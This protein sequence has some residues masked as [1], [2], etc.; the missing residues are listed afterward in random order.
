MTDKALL[1]EHFDRVSDDPLLRRAL[2]EPWLT[3]DREMLYA[4][5]YVIVHTSGSSGSMGIFVFDKEAWAGI[6]GVIM[7]RAAAAL[8]GNPLRRG[9]IALCAATH[10]RFGAVTGMKTLP[11]AIFNVQLCSVLDPLSKTIDTLNRF[12]PDYIL[13]YASTLHELAGAALDGRLEIRPRAISSAGEIL[14]DEAAA[15]MEKAF[16]T[17]PVDVYA[18]SESPCLAVQ[19]PG[20]RSLSLMED[21]HV[22]EMLDASNEP[23]S[24]GDVGQV[25]M[26]SLYNHVFPLIRYR[27]GD[28][29]TRGRR[30]PDEAFDS[31]LRVEGRVNDALPV[32]LDDESVDSI[33]P[34]VLSEFFVPGADKFQFVS[35]SPSRLRICYV[36]SA[37]C[38]AAVRRSFQEILEMK[39]ARRRT[40][41][42]PERVAQLPIDPKTG[43]YRLVVSQALVT[44]ERAD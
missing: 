9:R 31:I 20:R 27:M 28:Y 41:V 10:G 33:H 39:G 42:L 15:A 3:T 38:D 23:V 22:L 17:R 13:G 18:T 19:T 6:R 24:P 37:E 34:I 12:R 36:A 7:A 1:M 30:L 44:G 5:R 32:V 25:V 29:V 21:M 14:T 8:T 43:K 26:T 4:N 40:E 11:K 35:E 16:G 2:V